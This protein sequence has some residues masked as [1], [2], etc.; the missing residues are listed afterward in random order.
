M[1]LFSLM[2]QGTALTPVPVRVTAPG[3]FFTS[4]NQMLSSVL[5]IVLTLATIAV[6]F[7]LI[8]GGMDWLTSGG[9]KGKTESARNKITAAI[10]GLII[11]IS[12]WA[13]MLFVQQLTGVV[14]FEQ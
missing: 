12:A 13:I 2:A 4:F 6:L 3:G 11:V 8:W 10:I 1:N 14:I 9:D 7:F 5:S